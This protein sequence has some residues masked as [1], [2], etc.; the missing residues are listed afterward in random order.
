MQAVDMRHSGTHDNDRLRRRPADSL[1]RSH[2][3]CP[4]RLQVPGNSGTSPPV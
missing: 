1:S 3:V 2:K 4:A